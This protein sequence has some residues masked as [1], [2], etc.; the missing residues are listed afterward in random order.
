ML[1]FA[2]LYH[3]FSKEVSILMYHHIDYQ[4]N[5]YAI[6][7]DNFSKQL[8]ALKKKGFH[9]ISCDML[10]AHITKGQKLPQKPILITFDDAYENVFIQALP[11]LKKYQMTAAVFVISDWV[12]KNNDWDSYEQ[13]IS[14]RHMS[15]QQIELWSKNGM[16]VGSHTNSHPHLSTLKDEEIFNE[17]SSSKMA[18][19]NRLH[20]PV[21][22]LC[23]P[24]GNFDE[25]AEMIAKKIGYQGAF[26][27]KKEMNLRHLDPFALSRI[28]VTPSL[29][30]PKLLR[31]CLPW[32]K[33][34]KLCKYKLKK[35]S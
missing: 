19:E 7:P 20:L 4:E 3:H 17:L 13:K 30:V 5:R 33:V 12:G 9:T 2:F 8:A 25:R 6:T 21:K 34:V 23:Y 32:N 27:I 18:I 31:K 24:Y 29:S 15:W 14:A 35:I 1:Y 26:S 11:L 28:N 10:L 16:E 22:F